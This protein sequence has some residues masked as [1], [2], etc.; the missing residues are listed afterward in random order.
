MLCI[1]AIIKVKRG[2]AHVLADALLEVA[3]HVR[4]N[5]PQTQGF[6]IAQ[7]GE[8]PCI[9]TTYERFT[10]RTAMDNHN[11]S[12][13]VAHFF[14]IAKPI[15]DGEVTLITSNEISAK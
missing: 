12:D 6:F 13:V 15:L 9:F 4:Q 7:D 2:Y 5:E 8:D 10:D 11:G 3:A 1:T 14:A